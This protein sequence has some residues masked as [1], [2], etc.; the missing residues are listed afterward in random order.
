MP[1]FPSLVG[2]SP[3]RPC[4]SA[5][6]DRCSPV[7]MHKDPLPQPAQG[8]TN[9]TGRVEQWAESTVLRKTWRNLSSY[10]FLCYLLHHHFLF[11]ISYALL[12]LLWLR[13]KSLLSQ[14]DNK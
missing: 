7:L 5:D 3:T 10:S 4:S 8:W 13:K 14:W 12:V 6:I 1:W 9:W 11:V 2:F